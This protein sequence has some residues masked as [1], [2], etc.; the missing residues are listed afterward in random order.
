MSIWYN[1]VRAEIDLEA[2]KHNFRLLKEKCRNPIPVI[3]SNAY[4]HGLVPVS[5]VL[6]EHGADS[7]AVGT[8][9]E[10]AA[11]RL[12]PYAGEIISLLGPIRD[13]DYQDILDYSLVPFIGS[14]EHMRRLSEK[15]GKSTV[16]IALKF[17]TGMSRL[18]FEPDQADTVARTLK[19]LKNLKPVYLCSHLA[20]ADDPGE[21]K[22]TA[23]QAETLLGVDNTLREQGLKCR[24]SLANSAAVL[25]H[26]DLHL[27]TQRPGISLYGGN[28]FYGNPWTEKGAALTQ[29]MHVSAPVLEIRDIR[30]GQSISYGRTYRAPRRMRAA[31]VACGYADNYSRGLSNKGWMAVRGEKAPILGR[32]CMQLTAVDVSHIPEAEPGDRAYI[33]GGN[34]KWSVSVHELAG[35][36]GT[37]SYEVFCQLGQNQRTYLA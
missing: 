15:A 32:V 31:I 6:A 24:I 21:Q 12:T 36:W 27:D 7:L 30:P 33:L 18:G 29:A 10:G 26:P 1:E 16:P 19:G 28:P 34:G 13:R 23:L 4:G 25:A 8:A 9:N 14:L 5:R 2:V 37:I 20:A 3:K 17:D 22:F 35:W 11:L